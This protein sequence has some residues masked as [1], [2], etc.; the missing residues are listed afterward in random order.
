MP[1][2]LHSTSSAGMGA[3]STSAASLEKGS[4]LRP[5]KERVQST[6]RVPSS[7]M[8]GSSARPVVKSEMGDWSSIEESLEA[9]GDGEAVGVRLRMALIVCRAAVI[10]MRAADM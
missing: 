10:D 1:S 6:W 9:G 3:R 7:R 2:G 5:W 4:A 8:R